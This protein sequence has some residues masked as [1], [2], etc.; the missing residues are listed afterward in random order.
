MDITSVTS[1]AFG[2]HAH[3]VKYLKDEWHFHSIESEPMY[4]QGSQSL[5]IEQKISTSQQFKGN[6]I[7]VEADE[8]RFRCNGIQVVAQKR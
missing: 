3:T 5:H 4:S 7:R 2:W 1:F 6:G 8:W